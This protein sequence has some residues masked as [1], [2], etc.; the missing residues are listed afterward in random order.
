[1]NKIILKKTIKYLL[2]FSLILFII[3]L[4]ASIYLI[5]YSL[6]PSTMKKDFTATWAQMNKDYDGLENWR[7]SLIKNNALIDTFISTYDNKKM[8]MYI[9][10]QVDI[11]RPTVILVHGY[12]DNAIRMMMLAKMY[13]RDF[14][15]NVVLPDL[16]YAGMSE[17]DHVQ[18][19]WKDRLDIKHLSELL[20]KR[21]HN[22]DTNF[23]VH[24]ISMGAATTMMLS[25][26]KDLPSNIKVFIEDCG[27]TS[28]WEQFK[29]ELKEQFYLPSFPIL[30][31]A[32]I[33]NK[34]YNGWSFSEA[35][36]IDAVSNSDYPMLFIHGDSDDFVPTY[37]VYKLFEAK[38]DKKEIWISK[39]TEHAESYLNHPIEYTSKVKSFLS[40]YDI[41]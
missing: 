15:F 26:E 27:Y 2:S 23:I 24:G 1:M 20:S 9:I 17:G 30:Y 14:G 25:G 38:K 6:T 41:K 22:K 21:E 31:E 29:K 16:R 11:N 4:V 34:I 35:S 32:S 18:M 3:S 28:V 19:G 36:A 7:D 39:D 33:I 8:H 5:S 10:D 13:D 40:S 37:M 12:T